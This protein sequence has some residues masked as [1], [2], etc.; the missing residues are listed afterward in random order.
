R[1]IASSIF[2]LAAAIFWLEMSHAT[3]AAQ[4]L[5]GK[6]TVTRSAPG[7]ILYSGGAPSALSQGATLQPDD[8]I[9][10]RASGRVVIALGDGSQVVV[11]SGSRVELKNFRAGVPW[12]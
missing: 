4:S 7:A 6:A 11:F 1:Q 2:L 9:D 5:G 3:A 8:V 12:R 10:T